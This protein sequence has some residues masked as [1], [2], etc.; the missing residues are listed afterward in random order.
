MREALKIGWELG[1]CL[2]VCM[3]YRL[4]GFTMEHYYAEGSF[5]EVFF[6]LLLFSFPE[7]NPPHFLEREDGRLENVR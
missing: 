1:M 4:L 2:C 6:L 5:M 3:T 7:K